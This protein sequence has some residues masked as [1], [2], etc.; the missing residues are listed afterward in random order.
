MYALNDSAT[1]QQPAQNVSS[2]NLVSL[3]A[4]TVHRPESQLMQMF[5]SP[6]N[7]DT[8]A[9]GIEE[10]LYQ[11]TGRKWHVPRNEELQI[12]MQQVLENNYPVWTATPE[13][14]LP[15]LNQ[16]TISDEA[17]VQFHSFRRSQ[18]YDKYFLTERR[19]RTEPRGEYVQVKKGEALIDTCANYALSSPW[20]KRYPEF[21]KA[22]MDPNINKFR[23]GDWIAMQVGQQ[24]GFPCDQ[25]ELRYTQGSYGQWAPSSA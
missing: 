13:Q 8:I 19:E 6:Q 15:L 16:Y 18:L 10:Q 1:Y 7:I 2:D 11:W 3:F 17:T 4:R 5:F 22:F 9:R 25:L 21:K 23:D 24:M 12:S 14:G 20:R